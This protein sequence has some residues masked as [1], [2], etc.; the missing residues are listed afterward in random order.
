MVDILVNKVPLPV[1]R[2]SGLFSEYE[3]SIQSTMPPGGPGK[4]TDAFN[5]GG[6]YDPTS[7]GVKPLYGLLIE[8]KGLLGILGV[9]TVLTL[10]YRKEIWNLGLGIYTRLH[11]SWKM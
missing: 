10:V 1:S 2:P 6:W 11:Q 4:L 8:Y 3:P 7:Q 9:I 5:E